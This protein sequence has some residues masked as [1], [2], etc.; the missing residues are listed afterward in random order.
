MK[1][2]KLSMLVFASFLFFACESVVDTSENTTEST[3]DEN[4]PLS[5]REELTKEK[6]ELRCDHI[7]VEDFR[8]FLGLKYGTN[9]SE[10]KGILGKASSGE[11]NDSETAFKYKYTNTKR[12]PLIV[13]VNSETGDVETIFIEVLGL[14]VNFEQDVK[15]ADEDFEIDPCHLSLFGQSPKEI[16][17]IFGQADS[18]KVNDTKT[19]ENVRQLIYYNDRNDISVTFK[20]YK[21]QDNVLSSIA[22][23]YYYDSDLK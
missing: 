11:Y 9:E 22:V 10:L 4:T 2:L 14:G 1:T 23:D 17:S 3:T 13:Y 20:F 18:D 16:L 21:S 6:K 8:H 5:D 19:E 12:V 7:N 15:K